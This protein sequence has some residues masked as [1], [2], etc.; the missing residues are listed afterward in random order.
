MA[1]RDADA[2]SLRT[3]AWWLAILS[4]RVQSR[5]GGAPLLGLVDHLPG[6][7]GGLEAGREQD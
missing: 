2:A 1:A 5:P 6:R 7:G 3:G 4:E